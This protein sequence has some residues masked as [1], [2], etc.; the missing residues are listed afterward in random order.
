MIEDQRGSR[1]SSVESLNISTLNKGEFE[2]A[3]EQEGIDRRWG[4]DRPGDET[5]TVPAKKYR[6]ITPSYR[7]TPSEPGS[8]RVL[9]DVI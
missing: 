6:R 7:E 3:T 9:I 2:S 1:Q 5:D 4:V 8:V